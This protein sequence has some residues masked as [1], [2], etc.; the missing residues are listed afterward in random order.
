MTANENI[1]INRIL[2]EFNIGMGTLI[3]YLKSK[4]IEIEPLP[5]TK[6]TPEIY[7]LVQKEFGKEQIIK[8]QSKKVAIKVKDITEKSEGSKSEDG[9]DYVSVKEVFIKTSLVE[10]PTPPKVLGKIDLDKL[11][12]PASHTGAQPPTPAVQP[13]ESAPIK[14]ES[15]N[16]KEEERASEPVEAPVVIPEPVKPIEGS[17]PVIIAE[18]VKPVKEEKPA[19]VVEIVQKTETPIVPEEK[20]KPIEEPKKPEIIKSETPAKEIKFTE[21]KERNENIVTHTE[22]TENYKRTEPIH[23]ETKVEKHSGLKINGT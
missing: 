14:T 1:R 10:P 20:V 15:V 21:N 19:P 7:A 18:E 5:T 16:H 6:V 12:K 23:I 11:N 22:R 2:K 17:A 8:E 13:E 9:D 3:D 4:K